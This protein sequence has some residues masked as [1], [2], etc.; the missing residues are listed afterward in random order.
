MKRILLKDYAA[1]LGVT[2]RTV[3]N[4]IYAN[5]IKDE[6][7]GNNIYILVDERKKKP[8]RYGRWKSLN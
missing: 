7:E 1:Q 5:K 6:K 8:Q 3:Y 2:P 4:W